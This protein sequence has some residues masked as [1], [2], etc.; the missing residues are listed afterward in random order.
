MQVVDTAR[1]AVA[2]RPASDDRE[3]R[4]WCDA[5]VGEKV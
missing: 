5:L 2:L 1:P 3:D 4:R